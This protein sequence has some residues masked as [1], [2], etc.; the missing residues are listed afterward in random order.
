[1][2]YC[3]YFQAHVKKESVW[4]VTSILRSC[5][6]LAFDRNIELQKSIFEFFVPED[7]VADFLSLM[8]Y[9]AK[10]ELLSNLQQ[11]PNRFLTEAV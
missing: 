1:M 11:L 9:F 4:I 3:L 5:E 7:S 2:S 8:D 6:H 10:K